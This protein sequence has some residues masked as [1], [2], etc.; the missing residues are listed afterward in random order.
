MCS[1]NEQLDEKDIWKIY[2]E[3]YGD[4][5]FIRLVK[6]GTA[7]PVPGAQALWGTNSATSA[8]R[9]TPSRRLVVMA[10]IDNLMKGAAGQAVQCFNLMHGFPETTGWSSPVCTRSDH[11]PAAGSDRRGR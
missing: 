5:P 7:L 4:E 1:V 3:A 11:V 9:R 2:R 6:S 10:A 8:S